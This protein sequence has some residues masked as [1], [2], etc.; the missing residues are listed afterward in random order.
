MVMC[1]GASEVSGDVVVVGM[2]VDVVAGGYESS[3][4]SRCHTVSLILYFGTRT[5][6]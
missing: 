2:V 3:A 6:R 1:D 5:V 4:A